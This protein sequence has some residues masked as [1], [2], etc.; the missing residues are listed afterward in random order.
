MDSIV[1]HGFHCAE[2][3]SHSH[4][5]LES[6]QRVELVK[7]GASLCIQVFF[8]LFAVKLVKPLMNRDFVTQR[9]WLDLGCEKLIFNHSVNHAVSDIKFIFCMS[10]LTVSRVGNFIISNTR[11]F[12]LSNCAVTCHEQF[13]WQSSL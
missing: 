1:H 2:T 6:C 9:S 4:A 5:S 3:V 7:G 10:F 13:T 12:R 11:H 8:S